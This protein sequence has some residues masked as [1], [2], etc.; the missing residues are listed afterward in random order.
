MVTFTVKSTKDLHGRNAVEFVQ[1]LTPVK[2]SVYLEKDGRS[3][4]LKSILGLLSVN[5]RKNDN[6]VITAY[7]DDEAKYIEKLITNFFEKQ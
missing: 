1:S 5:V 2:S 4:N 7:T 3:I 6:L